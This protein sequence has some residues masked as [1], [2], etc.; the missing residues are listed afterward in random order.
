MRGRRLGRDSASAFARLHGFD[1]PARRVRVDQPRGYLVDVGRLTAVE[2]DRLMDEGLG[3]RWES[4]RHEFRTGTGPDL[5]ADARGHGFLH[6]G[7]YEITDHGVED[8][9]RSMISG[10]F[11][12]GHHGYRRN[13]DGGTFSFGAKVA[14]GLVAGGAGY[15]AIQAM[16]ARISDNIKDGA[17]VAVALVAAFAPRS[18]TGKIIGVSA[19]VV[20]LG[21]TVNRRYDVSGKINA[22]VQNKFSALWQRVPG[23]R[24]ASAPSNVAA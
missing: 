18:M 7:H 8:M 20:L 10:R 3:R 15:A 21:G 4:W 23:I 14:L 2:Y 11:L 6:G 17:S 5:A 22:W 16:P 1:V 9:K 13:P 19:G 12:S 24:D